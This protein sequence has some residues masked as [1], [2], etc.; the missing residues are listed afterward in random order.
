VNFKSLNA[1][2]AAVHFLQ[3]SES[4][5]VNSLPKKLHVSVVFLKYLMNNGST[6]GNVARTVV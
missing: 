4:L 1:L 6:K 5:L 3:L 2:N